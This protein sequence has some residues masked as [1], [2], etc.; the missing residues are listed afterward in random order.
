MLKLFKIVKTESRS[1]KLI[2]KIFT[3]L[4]III[5]LFN[6]NLLNVFDYY[7]LFINYNSNH[8]LFHLKS[9]HGMINQYG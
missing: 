5:I 1:V 2:S 8:S 7:E 6:Y 3:D 9:V 4:L